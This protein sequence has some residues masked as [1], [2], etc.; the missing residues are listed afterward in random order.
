MKNQYLIGLSYLVLTV[1]LTW[2]MAIS[3]TSHIPFGTDAWQNCWNFWWARES[4]V[5]QVGS[6]WWTDGV[7]YPDGVRLELTNWTYLFT[8]L[9]IPLQTITSVEFAL[10]LFLLLST[11][12]CAFCGYLLGKRVGLSPVASFVTGLAF[13]FSPLRMIFTFAGQLDTS[14]AFGIPLGAVS[15]LRWSDKPR[16]PG[17]IVTALILIGTALISWYTA[18]LLGLL[19]L[20]LVVY[21]VFGKAEWTCRKRT[22]PHLVVTFVLPLVILFPLIHRMLVAASAEVALPNAAELGAGSAPDLLAFFIPDPLVHVRGTMMRFLGFHFVMPLSVAEETYLCFPV[23][24]LSKNAFAGYIPILLSAVACL[25]SVRNVT[26]WLLIASLSGVFALGPRLHVAGQQ[27][28]TMPYILFKYVP[29]LSM[30]RCPHHFTLLY[31]LAL[32]V[33]A[34]VGI[35]IVSKCTKGGHR[36]VWLLA[37]VIVLLLADLSLAPNTFLEDVSDMRDSLQGI[38]SEEK[39]TVL[40]IPTAFSVEEAWHASRY[41]YLQTFHHQPIVCGY[42]SRYQGIDLHGVTNRFPVLRKVSV[43][44]SMPSS[45]DLQI[46]ALK[47]SEASLTREDLENLR[48]ACEQLGIRWILLHRTFV[49]ES[50]S[51]ALKK[52]LSDEFGTPEFVNERFAGF[53]VLPE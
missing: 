53:R 52:A 1:L 49:Q 25:Y 36:K 34:G 7:F 48:S 3:V 44:A 40:D 11:F 28:I 26:R 29:G 18:F 27:G 8:L 43:L 46:E 17:A 47:T 5:R 4:L 16:I 33:M 32:A 21:D 30:M 45:V 37:G 42:T 22:W 12:L 24:P 14:A 19:L 10:N 9:S 31:L 23:T 50:I 20:F 51:K 2:P 35:D 41:L 6:F 15:Y 38:V 39:A 13:G